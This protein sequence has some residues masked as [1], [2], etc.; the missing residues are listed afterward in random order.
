MEISCCRA[1]VLRPLAPLQ[2]IWGCWFRAATVE[3]L[4]R[5]P[6]MELQSVFKLSKSGT[7]SCRGFSIWKKTFKLG[8]WAGWMQRYLQPLKNVFCSFNSS[9]EGGCGVEVC[10]TYL[11]P[12]AESKIV[13]WVICYRQLESHQPR[14]AHVPPT[15]LLQ[16][17]QGLLT[18][19]SPHLYSN[20]VWVRPAVLTES[21]L[22]LRHVLLAGQQI[23]AF[24][25]K[26][27]CFSVT[28]QELWVRAVEF[29]MPAWNVAA[30][31]GWTQGSTAA[32]TA[33]SI[34][35]SSPFSGNTSV[36][37]RAGRGKGVCQQ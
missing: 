3:E 7:L 20:F 30:G 19:G 9:W 23:T 10:I 15:A 6:L 29:E 36:T 1:T 27:H 28:C 2:F 18:Q 11:S 37:L 34:D 26:T 4:I 17:T 25:P 14:Q 16:L 24:D 5:K 32:S 13:H 22:L 8:L 35:P 12:V 33:K 31:P 21:T